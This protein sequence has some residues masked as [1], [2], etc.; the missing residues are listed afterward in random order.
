MII[1]HFNSHLFMCKLNLEN[2][3]NNK[4][5]RY[6]KPT[7]RN[8]EYWYPSA[9]S[10][11][12]FPLYP[13]PL[14]SSLQPQNL[15]LEH[16]YECYVLHNLWSQKRSFLF[17]VWDSNNFYAI[18]H[19]SITLTHNISNM[20]HKYKHIALLLFSGGATSTMTKLNEADF[21]T[22]S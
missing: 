5:L 11:E 9:W 18:L 14:E 16:P 2:N 7:F 10:W 17:G 1:I 20:P 6:Y 4:T 21:T 22:R 8:S 12:F 3:Y 13:E 15:L 19:S